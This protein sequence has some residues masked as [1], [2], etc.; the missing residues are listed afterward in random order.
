MHPWVASILREFLWKDGKRQHGLDGNDMSKALDF[1]CT[2]Y[3]NDRCWACEGYIIFR[4]R[5]WVRTTVS[6]ANKPQKNQACIEMVPL[7]SRSRAPKTWI[8]CGKHFCKQFATLKNIIETSSNIKRW[9]S[10]KSTLRFTK[11]HLKAWQLTIVWH[12][13]AQ[14]FSEENLPVN[15]CCHKLTS[16]W[17][18]PMNW[19]CFRH[20]RLH[21]RPPQMRP[22]V[23]ESLHYT[24]TNRMLLFIQTCRSYIIHITLVQICP[25]K[26]MH[27]KTGKG[28]AVSGAKFRSA[29]RGPGYNQ[30]LRFHQHPMS[31]T[32][33]EHH[34]HEKNC[35]IVNH[36]TSLQI[37]QWSTEKN[38]QTYTYSLDPVR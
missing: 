26:Y 38:D 11:L 28:S 19:W 35:K 27:L 29:K 36:R 16:D 32:S 13:Q 25:N 4:R 14:I 2:M 15:G 21:I 24:G 37:S 8:K 6:V 34:K 20:V 23:L 5:V 7:A 3:Q 10:R 30:W 31:G 9:T 1:K 33:C 18:R 12:L 17:A 22:H